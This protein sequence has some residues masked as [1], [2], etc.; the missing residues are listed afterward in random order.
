MAEIG[1]MDITIFA[2]AINTLCLRNSGSK[3]I[4]FNIYSRC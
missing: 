4:Y 3:Y 2:H 1:G